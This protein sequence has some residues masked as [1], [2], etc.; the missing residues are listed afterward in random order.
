MADLSLL[1][2]STFVPRHDGLATFA[3]DLERSVDA[4][5]G[6]QTRVIAIES[7]DETLHYGRRVVGRMQQGDPDSYLQ[8]A[9]EV[10]RL[11]PQVVSVQHEY[12][13]W[14][15]WGDGLEKDYAVPF[16]ETV[17]SQGIPVVTTLHTIRP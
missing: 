10:R 4:Q 7:E 1:L 11:R 16:I 8:A 12:G 13:L 3:A 17:A 14:G 9:R 5:P 6:V 15:E 2:A